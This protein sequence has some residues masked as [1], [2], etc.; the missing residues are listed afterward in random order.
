MPSLHVCNAKTSLQ[1][2]QALEL[3]GRVRRKEDFLL[4]EVDLF[5]DHLAKINTHKSMSHDEMHPCV[6]RELVEMIAELLPSIFERSWQTGEVLYCRVP[7][8][9]EGLDSMISRGPF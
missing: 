3:S 5:R 9:A 6:L 7:A 1:E 4:I 2:S 8:L